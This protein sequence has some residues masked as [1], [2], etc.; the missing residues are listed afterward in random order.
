MKEINE[1][2][3]PEDI[4]YT[5]DHE[6]AR[7]EGDLFK[8]GISDYAQDHLGDVVFVELPEVDDEFDQGEVFG[9]VESTKAVS[10]LFMPVGGKIVEINEALEDA[11]EAVN[12]EPYKN[13]WMITVEPSDASDYDA[14]MD[15][16]KYIEML[17]GLQ[18]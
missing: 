6:W 14:L 18:E 9:S 15:K 1:L 11:P 2:I 17:K 8:V 13:G 3:L 4:R 16:G 12:T 10:D 7:K 5:K